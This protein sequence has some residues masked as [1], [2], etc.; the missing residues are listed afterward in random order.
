MEGQAVPLHRDLIERSLK[1]ESAAQFEL[2]RLYHKAMYNVS[3]RITGDEM[4]AEDILQESFVSAFKNLSQYREDASFGAWLKRIVINRSLNLVKKR[5][6]LTFEESDEM[7]ESVYEWQDVPDHQLEVAVIKEAIKQLPDGFRAVL[8]L[9]LFEGYDHAEIAEIMGI[10]VSTSKSQFNRAKK[11][12][13][14]MI[15]KEVQYG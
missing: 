4:D 5:N 2:Y 9:Y 6:R 8:T 7:T 15:H 10:T 14:E 13:R 3:L 1:G 11:K 12:L